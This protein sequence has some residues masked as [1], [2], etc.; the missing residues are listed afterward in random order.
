VYCQEPLK[1]FINQS[2]LE[3]HVICDKLQTKYSTTADLKRKRQGPTSQE[4]L[5][6]RGCAVWVV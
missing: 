1:K 2:P 5:A 4:L 6:E 3:I